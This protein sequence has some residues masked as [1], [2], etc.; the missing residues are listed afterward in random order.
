MNR[1][2]KYF[3]IIF[4]TL[5]Q[6]YSFSQADH[7]IWTELLRKHV[8]NNGH[9]DYKGF[10]K[11]SFELNKYLNYLSENGPLQ[12]WSSKRTMAYWI[13][14]Y[15]AY[16]IKLVI[17]NYPVKSIKEIGGKFP[18]V[19]SS[20]DIKFITINHEKLDLNNIEHTKLR[21]HFSDPRIHMAIVC[22]S[23]SCPILLNEAF[24]EDQL[25]AQ[26]DLQCR[27][28]LSDSFRNDV[29]IDKLKISMIFKW[30]RS[31]F[32]E[33]GGVRAFLKKYSPVAFS[34]KAKISYL[35]YDWNLN[36]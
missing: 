7:Q 24:S 4:L 36:E 19:N 13:N 9:V 14:A 18:F 11:D 27:K 35:E 32:K 23:R 17:Q 10:I 30:Y 22:A 5:V 33:V 21:K 8:S 2:N 15:N 6:T 1:M 12:T 26:L 28:F 16:T 29:G 25:D 31:D 3:L 20:W 34:D